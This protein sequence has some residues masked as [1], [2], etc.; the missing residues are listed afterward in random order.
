MI[1]KN[2]NF[3]FKDPKC[4][5]GDTFE[6]CNL[7]QASPNTEI[8]VGKKE[9]RFIR[10]NLVNCQVPIDSVIDRC[11]VAQISRCTHENPNLI[12]KGVSACAED[13]THRVGDTKQSVEITEDEYRKLK[14]EE[15]VESKTIEGLTVDKTVDS[16]GVTQ[17]TF[18]RDIYV[19]EDK[20]L[21]KG[22]KGEVDTSGGDIGS[23]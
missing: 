7:T 17:Q 6:Q 15:R 8:C 12:D 1:Y 21:G 18:K 9:L 3:S 19:Y 11:N 5:D 16:D 14:E 23:N 2:K 10:C 20:Y 13:C 4:N 22:A